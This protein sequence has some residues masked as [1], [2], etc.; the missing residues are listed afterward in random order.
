M[1]DPAPQTGRGPAPAHRL[2][3]RVGETDL[4]RAFGTIWHTAHSR[5]CIS[6]HWQFSSDDLQSRQMLTSSV[7]RRA[8]LKV[9]GFDLLRLTKVRKVMVTALASLGR[10]PQRNCVGGRG[11]PASARS[12]RA[13]PADMAGARVCLKCDPRTRGVTFPAKCF[14][15]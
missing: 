5:R 1:P 4:C 14:Q 2:A 3:L 15:L 9:A 11:S 6:A 10:G 13:T 7:M 12:G 8:Y